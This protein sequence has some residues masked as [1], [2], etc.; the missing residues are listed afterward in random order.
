MSFFS[1]VSQIIFIFCLIK[2]CMSIT[3]QE[4]SVECKKI[5]YFRQKVIRFYRFIFLQEEEKN[6]KVSTNFYSKVDHFNFDS[7][8]NEYFQHRFIYSKKWSK[9]D[10]SPIVFFISTS[11]DLVSSCQQNVKLK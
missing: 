1:L 7:N 5:F 6:L 8:A 11:S 2:F 10:S 4:L 3:T 9:G